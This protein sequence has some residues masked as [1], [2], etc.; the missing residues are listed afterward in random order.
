MP[1]LTALVAILRL[2]LLQNAK[3]STTII[4]LRTLV[5]PP[6][7]QSSGAAVEVPPTLWRPGWWSGMKETDVSNVEVVGVDKLLG[8]QMRGLS[9]QRTEFMNANVEGEQQ[10]KERKYELERQKTG[11]WASA[12]LYD[13]QSQH[14][15][16]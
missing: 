2:S 3:P 9:S 16:S 13:R 12:K 8:I 4:E 1:S 15:H 7:Q 10:G 6:A 11:E 14:I 5:M